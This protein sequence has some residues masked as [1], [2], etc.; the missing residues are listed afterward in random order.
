[1]TIGASWCSEMDDDSSGWLSN[2]ASEESESS[3]RF[4]TRFSSWSVW[5]RLAGIGGVENIS[6]RSIVCSF[7][8]DGGDFCGE[9]RKRIN[10]S[11]EADVVAAPVDPSATSSSSLCDDDDKG[12][13]DE[14]EISSSRSCSWSER[15]GV[16]IDDERFDEPEYINEVKK[17]RFS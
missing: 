1:M 9:S 15:G 10:G 2:D 4:F 12:E 3:S 17:K 14:R 11:W 6:R 16:E 5:E 8:E 13:D 7:W